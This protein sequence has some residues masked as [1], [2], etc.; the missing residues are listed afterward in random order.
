MWIII[1]NNNQAEHRD[2][3]ISNL[4]GDILLEKEKYLTK[5]SYGK[6]LDTPFIASAITFK[7]ESRAV[8]L[9]SSFEENLNKTQMNGAFRWISDKKLSY[10][11][12]SKEEWDNIIDIK[13]M[14]LNN[15]HNSQINKHN[16]QINKLLKEKENGNK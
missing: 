10:R 5:T 15:K 4:L 2:N 8:K 7:T 14:K 9:I 6:Y 11:K 12:L 1:V 3:K 16:S 13:I